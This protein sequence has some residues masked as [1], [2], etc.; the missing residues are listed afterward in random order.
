MWIYIHS[1][2]FLYLSFIQILHIPH[3]QTHNEIRKHYKHKYRIHNTCI[4][5]HTKNTCQ[6]LKLLSTTQIDSMHL[7]VF[8]WWTLWCTYGANTKTWNTQIL[9][10]L[11]IFD[12]KWRINVLPSSLKIKFNKSKHLW[13]RT[14]THTNLSPKIKQTIHLFGFLNFLITLYHYIS[15]MY[16]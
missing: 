13:N 3:T 7:A 10:H 16:L 6:T 2:I 14:H 9:L 8:I 1:P 11:K 4:K 5:S 15:N 12:D